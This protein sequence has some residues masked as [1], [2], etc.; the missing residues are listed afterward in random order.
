MKSSEE[1]R[2]IYRRSLQNMHEWLDDSPLRFD[3]KLGI[4]DA[5]QEELRA[6]YVSNGHCFAC[7]RP[8]EAC[9]CQEPLDLSVQ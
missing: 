9:A 8:L 1:L 2:Q 7:D 3:E 4:I 6:F 5:W